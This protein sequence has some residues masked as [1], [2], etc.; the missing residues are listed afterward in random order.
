[1]NDANSIKEL[2]E[3]AQR[4][5]DW[6][7]VCSVGS[8]GYQRIEK[9]KEIL[10]RVAPSSMTVSVKADLEHPRK[11]TGGEVARSCNR[12]VD[13]NIA[14]NMWRA[15]HPTAVDEIFIPLS[16]HCH[17]DECEDCFGC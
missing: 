6:V 4:L 8:S 5:L 13:C 10:A 3:A 9:L 16:F 2:C 17:D 12:H 7:P 15:K 11:D 14:E 1:M